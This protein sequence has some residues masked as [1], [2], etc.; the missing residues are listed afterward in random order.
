MSKFSSGFCRF[1]YIT[2]SLYSVAS[3]HLGYM[4]QNTAIFIAL[5]ACHLVYL[6]MI[7]EAVKK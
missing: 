1:V 6:D 3:Y 4:D 2:V 5:S 7:V